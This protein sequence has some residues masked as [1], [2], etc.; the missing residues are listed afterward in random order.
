MKSLKLM[1]LLLVVYHRFFRMDFAKMQKHFSRA[2]NGSRAAIK[3]RE[4]TEAI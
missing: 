2:L 1:L 3:S 4:H